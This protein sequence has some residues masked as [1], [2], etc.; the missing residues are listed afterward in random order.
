MVMM[1]FLDDDKIL[2]YCESFCEKRKELQDMK[3]CARNALNDIK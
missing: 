1:Q 3:T 2:E